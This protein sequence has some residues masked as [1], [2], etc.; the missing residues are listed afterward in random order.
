MQLFITKY[1]NKTSTYTEG[2]VLVRNGIIHLYRQG[3]VDMSQIDKCHDE[4]VTGFKATQRYIMILQLS[5]L[6][7]LFL[8]QSWQISFFIKGSNFFWNKISQH[9]YDSFFN[10]KVKCCDRLTHYLQ[11]QEEEIQ[12]LYELNRINKNEFTVTFSQVCGYCWRFSILFVLTGMYLGFF[13]SFFLDDVK[14][15]SEEKIQL[16]NSVYYRKFSLERIENYSVLNIAYYGYFVKFIEETILEYDKEKKHALHNS[17]GG[18]VTGGLYDYFY[19]NQGTDGVLKYGLNSAGNWIVMESYNIRQK[20]DYVA[21]KAYFDGTNA[22]LT[23]FDTVIKEV[24]K[25][26]NSKVD[27]V[28]QVTLFLMAAYVLCCGLLCALFYF[29]Y[30]KRKNEK[31][32]S[33]QSVFI[34]LATNGSYR[35]MQSMI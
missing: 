10:I 28:Y 1:N 31:I 29:P 17:F 4:V 34:V 11:A 9:T 16:I 6:L 8:L 5:I 23:L 7:S 2:N 32:L 19:D 22:T 13:Y 25:K 33:L 12:G 18:L 15:I 21:F 35:K 24:I 14:V 26:G 27:S 30:L 3:I 20:Y